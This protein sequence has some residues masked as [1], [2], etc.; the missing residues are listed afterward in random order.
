MNKTPIILITAL[1]RFDNLVHLAKD[2]NIY[3]DEFNKYLDIYW[4][5]CKDV[6]NGHGDLTPFF[7]YVKNTNI[8]WTMYDSG[9]PNE[10]NYGGALFNLPLQ[11][12]VSANNIDNPFV[13]VFD[14]DNILHP[15]FFPTFKLYQDNNFFNK[16][17]IVLN[18]VFDEGYVKPFFTHS[19]NLYNEKEE[20]IDGMN[21]VDPSAVIIRY[22]I[23]S[24]YNF[25]DSEFSYDFHWLVYL[26]DN[27]TINDNVLTNAED[28][29]MCCNLGCAYASRNAYHNHLNPIKDTSQID[30]YKNKKA[31]D[32]IIDVNISERYDK[33]HER[34]LNIPILSAKTKNK[35]MKLIRQDIEKGLS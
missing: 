19:I 20:F 29:A 14:D 30:I 25:Y 31:K 27:E 1:Y 4:V 13:Y 33:Q 17:V 21:I 22:N 16:D 15:N 3:Y 8:Y 11:D 2:L 12:F 6:Y 34:T 26:L 10:T 18:C 32:I 24:K 7:D 5:I 23:L 28:L 35:I 9:T